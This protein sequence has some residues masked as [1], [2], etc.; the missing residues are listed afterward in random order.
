MKHRELPAEELTLY[1]DEQEIEQLQQDIELPDVIGQT[2]ALRALQMGTEIRGRGYNIF[3]TGQPGTGRATAIRKILHQFSP[4][5]DRLKDILFVFNFRDPDYPCVLYL[6][7]GRGKEFRSDIHQ[8]IEN[9]KDLIRVKL[10]RETYR[11]ER[12]RLIS[13]VEQQENDRLHRFEQKVNDAGFQLTQFKDDEGE[14]T[15]I[16]P[17]YENAPVEFEKLQEL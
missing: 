6:P 12:D 15:D 5:I 3:V 4:S 2:R 7:R 14:S 11:K 16:L 13:E 17:V 9:M 10:D 1:I 8:F